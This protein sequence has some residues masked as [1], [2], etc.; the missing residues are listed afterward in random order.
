M[1]A[2]QSHPMQTANSRRGSSDDLDA[3][4]SS[5][6]ARLLDGVAWEKAAT[7]PQHSPSPTFCRR[8]CITILNFCLFI[9]SCTLFT[10][11]FSTPERSN[12][13][14]LQKTSFYSPIF[15]RYD[16]DFQQKTVV[17]PLFNEDSLSAE[18]ALLRAYPSPETEAL[19]D[20]YEE[21]GTLII[22]SDDVRLL[23]KDPSTT[24]KA[25]VDFGYG[26]D[27]HLAMLDGQHAIHCLNTLR[28][29]AYREYFYPNLTAS[30]TP[31]KSPFSPLAEA[32]LSHCLHILL[33]TL[34]CKPSFDLITMNWVETQINPY[35]DFAINKKCIDYKQMKNWQTKNKLSKEQWL[36]VGDRGP[37]KEDKVFPMAPKLAEWVASTDAE[38]GDKKTEQVDHHD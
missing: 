2:S 38:T 28:R 17:G 32:H 7:S 25:P 36:E 26:P 4:S 14:L 15:S 16:I 37:Q 18:E 20:E 23:G 10:L 21:I 30:T 9:I 11:S 13:W 8:H 5:S 1:E 34:T 29:Y 33:Q 19:W 31:G 24:V 22:S 12:N 35:P 6:E 3:P 27:A